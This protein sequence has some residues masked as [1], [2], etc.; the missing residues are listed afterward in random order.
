MLSSTSISRA[1]RQPGKV[2]DTRNSR[3]FSTLTVSMCTDGS[4]ETSSATTTGDLVG[5]VDEA[6]TVSTAVALT[7]IES[8]REVNCSSPASSHFIAGA[9]RS[10]SRAARSSSKYPAGRNGGAPLA[11]TRS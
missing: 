1:L 2:T 11:C 10:A 8:N 6:L 5:R 4:S 9:A 7:L 3:P